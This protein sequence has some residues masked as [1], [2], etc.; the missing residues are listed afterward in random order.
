MEKISKQVA[1]FYPCGAVKQSEEERA[2]RMQL[3]RDKGFIVHE[4]PVFHPS[5][6]ATTAATAV[7]RAAKDSHALT[8]RMYDVVWAGRG[9]YGSTSLL[10]FLRNMLPPVLPNKV[11]VGFSDVS[12]LGVTL[13]LQYP[14]VTYVHGR[15]FFTD[16][17]F[18]CDEVEHKLLMDVVA[19]REP[20]P[21]SLP[22]E[23]VSP[24]RALQKV[25]GL[26][27]PLNLSLAESLASLKNMQLP[28]GAVL[29]LE[30][31][32]ENVYQLL[33]KFDSI[34][35]SGILS[36]AAGVVIGCFSDCKK[37]DGEVATELE[38]GRYFAERTHLPVFVLPVFGHGAKK[39]P[40]V[41]LS[42]VEFEAHDKEWMVRIGF[43][44]AYHQP[45]CRL[46]DP[47]P[48]EDSL[49][50]HFTGIGG[51]G[52]ASVAGLFREGKYPI[53]G[54]DT[55]IFPP[56][57][58][59]IADM[60]VKLC[61]GYEGKNIDEVSPD[62]VVLSNVISRKNAALQGNPELERILEKNVPMLSFPSALRRFFLQRS[63]NIVVTGTHGK[64]TTTSLIAQTLRSM[65]LDPSL[66][67]G[68][69][70]KNFVS[71]Y[72]LGSRDL[73]VLEGDEYDTAYFDKGPKYMHYEPT[74]VLL[75]NIE[76]DHADIYNDVEAI[77]REF[78]R[79]AG[80]TRERGGVAVAN[81]FEHRVVGVAKAAAVPVMAFGDES[82]SASD[83]SFGV[84]KSQAPIWTLLG[85][86]TRNDGTTIEVK[87]P[88]G[89]R[90]RVES[91]VFG[92]HNVLNILATLASIHCYLILKQR[93]FCGIS[94]EE[95]AREAA[96]PLAASVVTSLLQG[97]SSF[98]GVKRRFEFVGLGEG[99][100]VFDDFAH[101]PTAIHTTLEAFRFY[102]TAAGRTGRLLACFDPRNAT[103]RR[104]V[105]QNDIAKSFLLAD[106]VFLGKVP[107]D[108]R[109]AED[110]RLDGPGLAKT[111]GEKAIYFDDN[112]ALYRH[113]ASEIKPG[114]TLVFMGPS[115][116]FSGFPQRIVH[117]RQ[118]V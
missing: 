15:N 110:E 19:G 44:R 34:V 8:R 31:C 112:D 29:F 41:A 118:G 102:M 16:D 35:N 43:A 113:V 66:F 30:D 69:A 111:V 12:F 60:G 37:P 55:P 23:C 4:L 78:Q 51:T 11:L 32:N 73:F 99:V 7:E 52:M 72:H 68:G 6:D 59:V 39:L 91:Q 61:V 17:M 50:I 63:R 107:Q 33:R 22:V 76:F 116:A 56:M 109:I 83:L 5:I 70:P 101:H 105:L 49:N 9:G 104:R 53:T 67:V 42:S 88:W 45:S 81:M 25:S 80:Y 106:K 3:M 36:E 114:D 47:C 20:Q 96:C 10:P 28:K 87:S 13:S 18:S 93:G 103:M 82:V 62:V 24:S 79:L 85:F 77:E 97:V 14:S 95:L 46:F 115:G 94:Q 117:E 89:D 40:L 1:V 26:C 48:V 38:I 75:N 57:D 58:K 21:L 74:V 86:T 108:L 64:T 65:G 98:E 2:T 100:A 71:G 54:S 84:N 92:R 90:L 27:I